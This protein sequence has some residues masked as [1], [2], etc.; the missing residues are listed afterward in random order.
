MDE[1]K[2]M[3]DCS[4]NSRRSF[5]PLAGLIADAAAAQNRYPLFMRGGAD[6]G[7]ALRCSPHEWLPSTLP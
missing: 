5:L 7:A 4:F 1:E 2:V 3:N 6:K